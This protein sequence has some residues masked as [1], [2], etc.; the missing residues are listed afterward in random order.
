MKVL[1]RSLLLVTLALSMASAKKRV[2]L[3]EAKLTSLHEPY[4]LEGTKISLEDF[5]TFNK[6]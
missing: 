5:M 1:L 3:K 4:L 6:N 2:V